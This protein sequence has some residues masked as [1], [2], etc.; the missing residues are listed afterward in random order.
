VHDLGVRV[1]L[2]NPL[3]EV[4]FADWLGSAVATLED[5]VPAEVPCGDCN[6][7]CRTHHYIHVRPEEKHAR[8]RLP[9]ESLYPAPGLPPG[10]L[11]IGPDEDGCCPLLAEGRC[12]VYEDRPLAC[13]TY[14]C[15]VYA[16]TGVAPDRADIAAQV[17]RWRF[18]YPT[19]GDQERRAAVHAAVR[20]IREHPES[21]AS[22]A[23]R[24][25]PIRLA[26]LAVAVHEVFQAGAVVGA[27][28]RLAED[29][30][31]VLAIADANERLFG[32]G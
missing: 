6:A 25:Q 19:P 10:Y 20:F 15:R 5:D 9:R 3:P 4:R 7:C 29:R 18:T 8:A 2:E 22:G 28:R 23:A 17:R 13:R 1:H 24:L 14:D 26:T 11:V 21:L 32:D 12:T 31:R 16:A 27:R 30:D